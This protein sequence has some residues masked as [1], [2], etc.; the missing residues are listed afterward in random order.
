MHTPLNVYDPSYTIPLKLFVINF[1]SVMAKRASFLNLIHGHHPDIIFGTETWLSPEINTTEFLP[2]GYTLF[3]RDRSDGYGGVLLAFRDT[4]SVTEYLI[5]NYSQCEIIACNLTYKNEKII[6]CSVYRPPSADTTYLQELILILEEIVIS[7]PTTTIWI[8]GDLNFP[9][10]NWSD[11]TV[12]NNHYPLTLYNIFLDFIADH[13]FFQIV[14]TPTRNNSIL[15]LF[16]TNQ[17][18]TIESCKVI[19]GISDHEIVSITNTTTIPYSKPHA[20]NILL[21]HKADLESINNH[22]AQF[23]NTFLNSHD[24]S[25]SIDI[26]WDEFKM[27]CKSCLDMIPQKKVSTKVRPSWLTDNIRRLSRRKQRKYNTARLTNK[28]EDWAAYRHLKKVQKLCR[29]SHN[30]YV[31]SLLDSHNKCTK[32]F[33]KYIKGLRKEQISINTLHLNGEIHTDSEIKA[34]I[35]NNQFVSVFTEEDRLPLPNLSGEPIPNI[36]QL[37]VEV[38]GVLSLLINIDPHKATGPDNIPP[39]LLRETA[40]QMAP[41]LTFIFQSS[42][43]QGKLPADWKLANITPLYKKGSRTDP[44]N[45]RPIS[46]TSVCCKML[47]HIIY[48]SI[49][50]H[51]E[52]HNVLCDSQH[53]FRTRRSC[54]TQLIGVINDFQDCLNAG[55]HIDALFLDFPKAF[56][57]VSHSKLCHK[58]SH[59]GI[60][61]KILHWIK[62][63]LTDRLQSV[64]LEGKSSRPHPVLSGV[65]QGT[66]LGPLL[67]LLYINDIT[68]PIKSTIRLYADDILMYRI[69]NSEND[70]SCLQNDLNSL[71]NWSE[72]WQMKFNPAKCIHLTI[73]NKK[74]YIKYCYQIYDQYIKQTSSA[75]YLGVTIDRHLTWKDHINEICN[76]ANITKAFLKRNIHQC[77]TSIKANCYKSFVRPILEY[78]A[79]IWSPHLQYQTY[80]L[81]KIQRSAARFVM[82]DYSRYS[83]VSNM[84]NH[85][86]WPTLEQRRKYIKLVMFF[87][88]I[89]GLVDISFTLTLS[90]FNLITR[91]HHSR[92]ILPS[93]RTETY[94]HSYLPSTLKLWNGLAT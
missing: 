27:L 35:L 51:L 19:P 3:R 72:L 30:N 65:P 34:N 17:P 90:P 64:V 75:K 66:V 31:L 70:C 32:K 61:G 49:F 89:H 60:N 21:W 26:L 57:K 2:T 58:L 93:I 67:F 18:S 8:G 77:P 68:K 79:M 10:I 50:S 9:G 55:N 1:Q 59:Y 16:L 41:L 15:D 80:Q 43:D 76:K 71:G 74:I 92:Y 62:D 33:W 40:Y 25:D 88:I 5:N 78:A 22:I 28:I 91:G 54:E 86:S 13:G 6:I 87:K 37:S 69:I 42:L 85:L 20:R 73:T 81:E 36:T 45:Y 29:T 38:E 7:N 53:G 12:S 46:L 14:L 94:L 39:R 63:F 83:S 4:F 52:R 44:A 24:H 84:L 56:D 11:N 47:E 48:S 82:N 23:A